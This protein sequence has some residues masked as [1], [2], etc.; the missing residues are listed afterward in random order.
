MKPW[1]G[2]ALVGTGV[3]G[4]VAL[5]GDT[6]GRVQPIE[7]ALVLYVWLLILLYAIAIFATG[8]ALRPTPTDC[9]HQPRMDDEAERLAD[10]HFGGV[11][12]DA[13]TAGTADRDRRPDHGS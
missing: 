11:P 2:N 5:V 10:R 13:C 4:F 9:E 6:V 3:V 8:C 7:H 12:R 1:I